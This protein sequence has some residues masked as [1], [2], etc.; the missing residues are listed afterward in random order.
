LLQRQ[1]HKGAPAAFSIQHSAA[2]ASGALS[3]TG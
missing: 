2:G 3:A 1:Q